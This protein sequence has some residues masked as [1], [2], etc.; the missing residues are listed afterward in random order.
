MRF[1]LYRASM[2][3][4]LF[5]IPIFGGVSIYTYGVMVATGFLVALLWIRYECKREGIESKKILDLVFY[6]VLFGILGSRLFHLLISE[7]EAFF[8]D[9]LLFFKMWRAGLVYYG[10]VISATV[11]AIIYLKKH[12]LS[13]WSSTDIITPGL[14]L[15]HLFGRI[16]CFMSGCCYGKE[17]PSHSWYC[18]IFPDDP[19]AFAPSGICLFP[20]QLMEVA[21]E[22]LIFLTLFFLIRHRRFMGQV[23]ATYLMLYAL[24]RYFTE[25]FRGD[26]ERGFV[27][28]PWI[29]TS[30]FISIGMFVA[31]IIIYVVRWGKKMRQEA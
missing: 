30:Q 28:E 22:A 3:P 15:G 17:A 12:K 8:A 5:K 20:T 26:L 11:V 16:G 21:G 29:S 31:G 13:F 18:V 10:G 14:S 27:V 9:P 2:H 4:I 25:I 19:H 23:F 7:R 6:L 1:C 24:L